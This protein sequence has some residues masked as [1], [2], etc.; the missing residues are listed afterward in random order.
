LYLPSCRRR[1]RSE[2]ASGRR[3]Y[4]TDFPRGT[5]GGRERLFASV[6]TEGDSVTLTACRDIVDD[7]IRRTRPTGLAGIPDPSAAPT[8]KGGVR[9]GRFSARRTTA[10]EA[11]HVVRGHGDQWQHPRQRWPATWLSPSTLTT[12]PCTARPPVDKAVNRALR[13][14]DGSVVEI[15]ERA[16]AALAFW[17]TSTPRADSEACSRCSLAELHQES[18]SFLCRRGSL[19][20]S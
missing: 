15:K 1:Q 4:V 5:L 20:P 12:P 11:D 18:I 10:N 8:V 9:L 16:F 14:I 3:N 13:S 6:G 7:S 19:Q 2:R 17:P